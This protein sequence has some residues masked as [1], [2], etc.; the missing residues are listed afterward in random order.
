MTDT[1]YLIIG[2]SAAAIGG[3]T[4][5]RKTDPEGKL[6]LV[7]SENR[8]T[9]SRPLISYWL[10]GKV[11]MENAIYRDLDFYD[12]NRCETRLGRH[13]DSINPAKKQAVLDDGEVIAYDKLLLATGSHPFVPP[14]T[15]KDTAKN[16]FTFTTMDDAEGVAKLLTETS[17]VVILGA[18]LIGLKAA[19]AVVHQC[20]S[21]TVLDL[22]D[23]VLPSVLDA[24]AGALMADHLKK[25]GVTLRLETSITEIGDMQ[26]T[27]SDGDVL[28]YDILIL[29]VGTRPAVRLA[30]DAGLK[31]ER[32]I[33]TDDHQH[34]SAADIYA[35]G[36]CTLSH[37]ISSDSDKNIAILPNAYL[38]GETAGINMAG[39]DAVMEKLF[40]ANS[41]GLLGL[42]MLTAGSYQGD[43]KIVE[44]GDSFRKFFIQDDVLKGYIIIGSCPRG[45]IYTDLIREKTDLS[46]LDTDLL[47]ANPQLAAFPKTGRH[48][49]LSAAH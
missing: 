15:G 42:Y 39:G 27:L 34:T 20:A 4:G 26:V 8:H 19:E 33:I 17:R 29:A 43:A 10:E 32:G 22:S 47:F 7:S 3:V 24:E 6:I 37:D 21:V 46:T 41:M 12:R 16:A 35:A 28:P 48:Q 31:V 25:Q 1:K 5:I 36:D 40:P 45:G 30:E 14:I 9:Y 49:K 23:R 2:N 18:G 11:K 13:V 38:Q 44:T